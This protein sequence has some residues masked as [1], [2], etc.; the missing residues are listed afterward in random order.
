MLDKAAEQ[1]RDIR[2]IVLAVDL[3]LIS[4]L[5]LAALTYL[6]P[7]F[8]F[9]DA[10]LIRITSVCLLVI[11]A[12]ALLS[13]RILTGNWFDPYTL[14]LIA[15]TLFNGGQGILEI[16]DLNTGGPYQ[17]AFYGGIYGGGILEGR[18]SS[19]TIVKTL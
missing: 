4:A 19:A 15:A 9:N 14:F 13:W 16:F 8:S 10:V 12:W 18:F 2:F 1:N 17:G 3:L 7:M 6:H 5:L 11:T